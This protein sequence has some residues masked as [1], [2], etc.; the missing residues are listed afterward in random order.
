MQHM[1]CVGMMMVKGIGTECRLDVGY[2]LCIDVSCV[3]IDSQ[4]L[5]RHADLYNMRV[6][7]A[8]L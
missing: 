3:C 4:K 1:S 6:R 8:V 2:L 7:A 5:Y